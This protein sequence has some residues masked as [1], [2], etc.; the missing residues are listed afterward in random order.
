MPPSTAF[1][2]IVALGTGSFTVSGAARV[3][4]QAAGTLCHGLA[5]LRFQ[6][7]LHDS[8]SVWTLGS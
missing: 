6:A 3:A 1:H 8:L 7:L 4:R 2:S 5:V